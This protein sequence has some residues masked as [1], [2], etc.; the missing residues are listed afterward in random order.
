MAK[1][2]TVTKLSTKGISVSTIGKTETTKISQKS[3]ARFIKLPII[4]LKTKEKIIFDISSGLIPSKK[5]PAPDLF[6]YF[7]NQPFLVIFVF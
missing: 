3:G 5:S 4:I 1:I 2:D 6:F 7:E